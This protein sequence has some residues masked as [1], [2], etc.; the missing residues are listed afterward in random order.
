MTF[1]LRYYTAFIQMASD[2]RD[3]VTRTEYKELILK[4]GKVLINWLV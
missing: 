2:A 4:K 1:R 3:A